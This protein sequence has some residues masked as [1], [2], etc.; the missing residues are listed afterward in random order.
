M[1]RR[2]HRRW[3][4]VDSHMA[5]SSSASEPTRPTLRELATPTADATTFETTKQFLDDNKDGKVS[6]SEFMELDENKDGRVSHHEA[7]D[8]NADGK[9]THKEKQMLDSND[10]GKVNRHEILHAPEADLNSDGKVTK[11]ELH[12]VETIM[13]PPPPPSLHGVA[14]PR[15][16]PR[17]AWPFLGLFNNLEEAVDETVLV[18]LCAVTLHQA[19]RWLQ[20]RVGLG[21]GKK[22]SPVARVA[23]GYGPDPGLEMMDAVPEPPEPPQEP[24]DAEAIASSS[25]AAAGGSSSSAGF[26]QTAAEADELFGS[27]DRQQTV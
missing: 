3:R 8:L 25:A 27:P 16:P 6:K 22:Y 10:D 26:A 23:D 20:R 11:S 19:I 7:S 17:T 9:V 12:R 18:L 15:P 1:R 5:S 13:L 21:G 2:A 14:P 4:Q 24:A